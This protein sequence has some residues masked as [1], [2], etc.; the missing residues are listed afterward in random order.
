MGFFDWFGTKK[1]PV[2][3]SEMAMRTEQKEGKVDTISVIFKGAEYFCNNE[4][5]RINVKARNKAILLKPVLV[6][7][8]KQDE[9]EKRRKTH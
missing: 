1:C 2:C 7:K 5:C 9:L 3:K 6:H 8:K 4:N